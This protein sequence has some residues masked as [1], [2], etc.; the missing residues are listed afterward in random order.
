MRG[1]VP[2]SVLDEMITY[3]RQR[4]AEYDEWWDR[5]GRYDQGPDLN[6]RWLDEREM[7]YA[8]LDSMELRGQVLELAPGTGIWTQRLV[9]T[10]TT[11][12][13]VDASPEMIEINRAKL[14]SSRVRYVQADLFQWQPAESY[15]AVVFGFWV[16][17]V[18]IERLEEFFRTVA[19]AVHPGGRVFFVD[20]RR[21]PTST[22]M[23]HVLPGEDEQVMVRRLNDD[24]AFRIVKNF[25]PPERLVG[26][27]RQVGLDVQISTT[28][29]Y[30][31]YG[32]GTRS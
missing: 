8:A 2:T 30:F 3:Y 28:P 9:R 18:P 19:Q 20:G 23:N 10:A 4:S 32:Q 7:V 22:A 6:R 25:H 11:V 24:R 13:A 31:Y 1:A 17:H 21:E 16:S 15:N 29:T 26:V 27:C 12:T 14:S 5:R